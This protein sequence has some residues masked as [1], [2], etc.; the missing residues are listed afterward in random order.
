LPFLKEE[1][2]FCGTIKKNSGEDKGRNLNDMQA[3]PLD[4][5]RQKWGYNYGRK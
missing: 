5:W 1:Q 4:L 3:G 2:G